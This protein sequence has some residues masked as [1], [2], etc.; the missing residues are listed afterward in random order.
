MSHPDAAL[1]A[2]GVRHIYLIWYYSG[3][4]LTHTF[5]VKRPPEDCISLPPV[6]DEGPLGPPAVRGEGIVR[7]G[8]HSAVAHQV[9]GLLCHHFALH[10]E[11]EL[12]LGVC[13][14]CW[15]TEQICANGFLS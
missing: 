5:Y 1:R 8:H 6:G 11:F 10:S 14:N 3:S 13:A 4:I 12:R 2:T 9:D 7:R 15:E